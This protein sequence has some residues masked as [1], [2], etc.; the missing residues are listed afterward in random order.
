MCYWS[1]VFN[2]PEWLNAAAPVA[3]NFKNRCVEPSKI[4]SDPSKKN[5]PIKSFIGKKDE[6][7]APA[8]LIYNQW[9]EVKSLATSHG[10]EKITETVLPNKGHAPMPEEVM[11]YFN[12][13]LLK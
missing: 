13:L 2:H 1:I 8:V 3:G 9:T 7:F 12:S 5:L 4:S 11:S 6:S 10:F